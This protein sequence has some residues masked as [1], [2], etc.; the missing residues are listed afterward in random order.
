MVIGLIFTS[1]N[2]SGSHMYMMKFNHIL[3]NIQV[4][5]KYVVIVHPMSIEDVLFLPQPILHTKIPLS[6]LHRTSQTKYNFHLHVW[7]DSI[8]SRFG[9]LTF[10]QL[11]LSV[12]S[13]KNFRP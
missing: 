7:M 6:S 11:L 13:L 12:F 1:I 9:S 5:S 3:T 8:P 10:A 4:M 2:S